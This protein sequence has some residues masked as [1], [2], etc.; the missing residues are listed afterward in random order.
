MSVERDS[1][2]QRILK[3]ILASIKWY[4]SIKTSSLDETTPIMLKF[5]SSEFLS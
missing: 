3:A 5:D 4:F 2:E 1:V